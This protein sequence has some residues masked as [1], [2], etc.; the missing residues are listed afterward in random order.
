MIETQ[1]FGYIDPGGGSIIIQVLLGSLVGMGLFFRQ[2]LG[3]VARLLR[4]H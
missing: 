1:F 3:R 4:R 2:S